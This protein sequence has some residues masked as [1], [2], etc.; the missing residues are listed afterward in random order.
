M[1]NLNNLNNASSNDMLNVN[2]DKLGKDRYRMPKIQCQSRKNNK[3]YLLNLDAIAKALDRNSEE[4]LKYLGFA[5]T[6]QCNTK[7]ICLNGV[8]PAEKLQEELF[9][10]IKKYVLCYKCKNPETKSK[11]SKSS[12]SIKIGCIACGHIHS[13]DPNDKFEKWLQKH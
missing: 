8:F 5:L 1:L 13:I 9:S 12:K 3:T 7:Q 11:Y 10:Y 4:L 6:T 2:P